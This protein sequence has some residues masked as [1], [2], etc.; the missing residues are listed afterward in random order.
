MPFRFRR[1]FKV[2]PGLKL[3][4]RERGLSLSAGRRGAHVT[5]GST[6]VRGTVG[7]PGS[8]L[9]YTEHLSWPKVGGCGKPD[10]ADVQRRVGA[11]D[12][13]VGWQVF[14]TMAAEEEPHDPRM[15]WRDIFLM[16]GGLVVLMV[17]VGYLLAHLPSEPARKPVPSMVAPPEPTS[18]AAQ[19]LVPRAELMGI[20]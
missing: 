18:D 16:I 1:T 12:T 8:G 13:P 5:V 11:P 15:P 14:S 2:L 6:G 4:V 19:A 10:K 9:S 3:N 7:L 20:H 17:G